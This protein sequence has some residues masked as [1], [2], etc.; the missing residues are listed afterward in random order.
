MIISHIDKWISTSCK[1]LSYEKIKLNKYKNNVLKITTDYN[2]IYYYDNIY[3]LNDFTKI[4][5]INDNKYIYK[6]FLHFILKKKI[7]ITQNKLLIIDNLI[8]PA[9]IIKDLLNEYE[10]KM[11]IYKNYN[12][13]VTIYNRKESEIR[14]ENKNNKI[15]YEKTTL[16][17]HELKIILYNFYFFNYKLYL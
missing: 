13:V 3:W 11:Q 12:L 1:K 15:N 10:N 8:C 14:L 6:Q 5:I 7:N 16:H 9:K 2:S 17:H 4:E